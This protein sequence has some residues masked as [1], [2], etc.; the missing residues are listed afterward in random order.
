MNPK[1]VRHAMF[2][3]PPRS[4]G[5]MTP[6]KRKK[7]PSQTSIVVELWTDGPQQLASRHRRPPKVGGR[8]K[9]FGHEWRVVRV[10]PSRPQ[11]LIPVRAIVERAD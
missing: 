8:F 10:E 9:A 3:T 1:N 4:P 6:K 2:S 7:P 11:E 5:C